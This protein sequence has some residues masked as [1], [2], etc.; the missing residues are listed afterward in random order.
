MVRH[1]LTMAI[2]ELI[3][4]V[5]ERAQKIA[6]TVTENLIR[7]DFALDPDEKNLKTSA[8]HMV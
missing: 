1:A 3:G 4:P 2:K 5:S 6:M 8:F 7:K